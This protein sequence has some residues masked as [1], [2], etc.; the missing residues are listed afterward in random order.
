MIFKEEAE[1]IAKATGFIQRQRVL[2]GA[3]FLQSL[4]FG[5]LA[6]PEERLSGLAQNT[7]RAGT[8]IKPQSLDQRF[9]EKS[10]SFMQAMLNCTMQH[11]VQ[12]EAVKV[13]LFKPFRAVRI[14]DSS[15]I[16]VPSEFAEH[17]PG[18]GNQHGGSASLKLQA[19]LD[20]VRGALHCEVQAGRDSDHSSAV[21]FHC[22]QG[23]LSVR[24]LGYFGVK[25]FEHIQKQGA[26]F[27]SRVPADHVFYDATGKKLAFN[28][29]LHDG[30]DRDVYL[31][32]HHHFKVRLV[33]LKVPK[34]VREQRLQR[35]QAEAK[36]KGRRVCVL[37]LRLAGWDIR[38]TNASPDLLSLEAVFVLSRLRWQIELCFKLF[39]SA[40][41]LDQSRSRKP[42]RILTELFAK[43]LGCLV[44]HWCIVAVAWQLPEKSLFRLA[45]LV[46]AE[47]LTL[48]RALPSLVSLRLWLQDLRRIALTGCNVQRRKHPA[49]FQ[50][51]EKPY[52]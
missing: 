37:A 19:N 26:Y 17:Y 11:I 49:A 46:Q 52:A 45:A 2:T 27:L 15:S 34:A 29:Y 36:R 8:A 9:T 50:L 4:V 35:L 20:L 12:A 38:I 42:Q 31:G 3:S 25:H 51:L 5:W 16:E 40:N 48:L 30:V 14:A 21:A 33:V 28:Q 47:A 39:K 32:K 22:A 43:L 41:L 23:E 7:V 6:K 1:R 18:C 44:Q 13:D 24:D 10:V